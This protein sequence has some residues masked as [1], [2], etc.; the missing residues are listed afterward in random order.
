VTSTPGTPKAIRLCPADPR[1]WI[2]IVPSGSDAV[3]LAVR[4]VRLDPLWHLRLVQDR[5]EVEPLGLPV[6]DGGPGV[7]PVD[8]AYH[9]GDRAEAELGHQL[10]DLFGEHEEEVDD[11]LRLPGELLPQFG[12]LRGDADRAGVEVALPH[13][14]AAH[15]HQ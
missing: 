12:I 5:G 4:A 7:E 9:L 11:V 14:D 13:H 2:L 6:G 10:T 15:H 8:A 3:I 1:K